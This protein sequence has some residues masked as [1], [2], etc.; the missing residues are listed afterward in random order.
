MAQ[1]FVMNR[2]GSEPQ[3]GFDWP[4]SRAALFQ[5]G[6][7]VPGAESMIDVS[8]RNLERQNV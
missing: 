8:Q 4:V 5:A 7:L 6:W 3:H 2:H 1:P